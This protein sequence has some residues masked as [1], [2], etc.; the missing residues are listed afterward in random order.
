MVPLREF[1]GYIIVGDP[2]SVY[3][4]IPAN[5]TT[6]YHADSDTWK[7]IPSA[8]GFKPWRRDSYKALETHSFMA[9]LDAT[10]RIWI[11]GVICGKTSYFGEG[12]VILCESGMRIIDSTFLWQSPDSSNYPPNQANRLGGTA[13]ISNSNDIIYYI[14]GLE[15]IPASDSSDPLIISPKFNLQPA[16]MTD[17][18]TFDTIQLSWARNNATSARLPTAREYHTAIHLPDSDNI[19]IYGGAVPDDLSNP[20][21]TVD[22]YC[23][24]LNTTS[25][26]WTQIT[27][28]GPYTGAGARFGHSA[29]LY[30]NHSMFIL[31]G[32]D[33]HQKANND[34]HVMDLT[35]FQWT[36]V[37]RADGQY[38]ENSSKVPNEA[39]VPTLESQGLAGGMVAG[40]VVGSIAGVA[41]IASISAFL[42]IRKKRQQRG[43]ITD[44][45]PF[46]S[47]NSDVTQ[48]LAT[49]L[50]ISTN[51]TPSECHKPDR[52]SHVIRYL[53]GS[54]QK[55]DVHEPTQ[56]LTMSPVEGSNVN[57]GFGSN[58][59]DGQVPRLTFEATKPDGI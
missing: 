51:E 29:V 39:P 10:N 17:I 9:A 24:T 18:V 57:Y 36:N 2:G 41:I 25:F 32:V 38:S 53:A 19:L 54:N 33:Q 11:W 52:D 27:N 42:L 16:I 13:T 47:T 1:N 44:D 46:R 31:F 21:T 40:I 56:S 58:K 12:N 7:T 4:T 22:D 34:F 5:Q 26:V 23:Y 30:G 59:P 37:F 45:E 55:P 3:G 14:G 43:H 8:G 15:A 28:F 35:R 50:L 6:V 49:K 20:N 48:G